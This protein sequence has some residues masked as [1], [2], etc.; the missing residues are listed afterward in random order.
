MVP[1]VVALRE[2][3]CVCIGSWPSAAGCEAV[4]HSR[5]RKANSI[6]KYILLGAH[7]HLQRDVRPSGIPVAEWQASEYFV[8]PIALRHGVHRS[9]ARFL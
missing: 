7:D 6:A 8:I 9:R 4:R 1:G 3:A 2:A 5:C